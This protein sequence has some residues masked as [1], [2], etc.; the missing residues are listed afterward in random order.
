MVYRDPIRE[1]KRMR[2]VR[3]STFEEKLRCHKNKYRIWRRY[4]VLLSLLQQT[5]T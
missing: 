1:L 2:P 5:V 4:V 3:V